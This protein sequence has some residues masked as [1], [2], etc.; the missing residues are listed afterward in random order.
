MVLKGVRGKRC[1]CERE[2]ER[3]R[4]EKIQGERWKM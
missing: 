4:W 2:R 3:E 1:V